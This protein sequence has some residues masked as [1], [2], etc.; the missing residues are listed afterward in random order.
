MKRLASIIVALW[1]ACASATLA[2]D[3]LRGKVVGIADGD[4]LTVLD[5]R[6][7]RHAI[8][9]NGIDAPESGQAF[10]QVAKRSLSNLVFGQ[11]V[12]VTWTKID[13]YGRRVGTVVRGETNANLE[14]L[15][16]GF[17]WY[18]REYASDVAPE[19]R[20]VYEAA[21]QAARAAKRGLWADARQVPPWEFRARTRPT[22][23]TLLGTVEQVQVRGNLKSR[24]Y[25]L[26]GCRNYDDIAPA[27]RVVFRSEVEAA[28]AGYRKAANCG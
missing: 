22:A 15:R 25:H 18:Y 20:P 24:I 3:E 14:Q 8:R 26:P 11:D 1:C 4:T 23:T 27:N 7:Q 12:V 13:R 5:A 9:L 28:A 2:A 21:E 17:A 16:G 19:D 10:G 6:H